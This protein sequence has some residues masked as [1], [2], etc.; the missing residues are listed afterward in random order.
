MLRGQDFAVQVEKALGMGKSVDLEARRDGKKIA[1]EV[2]T[3]KSDVIS[4]IRKDLEAGYDRVLVV[5]LEDGL[6]GKILEKMKE[7]G[8]NQT[9]QV[10]VVNLKQALDV[11][12]LEGLTA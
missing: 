6:K 8:L 3:G 1:I 5:C 7:L 11:S 9:G 10:T 4:N 2:E 12:V